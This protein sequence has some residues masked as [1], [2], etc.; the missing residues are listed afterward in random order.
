MKSSRFLFTCHLSCDIDALKF[1]T[2]IQAK[3]IQPVLCVANVSH[4]LV[5]VATYN[6]V[7]GKFWE[8]ELGEQLSSPSTPEA[9][10][11]QDLGQWMLLSKE[12]QHLYNIQNMS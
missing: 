6:V 12:C 2:A 7:N 9:Q 1:K 8:T 4:N 3:F 10:K 11:A 5:P